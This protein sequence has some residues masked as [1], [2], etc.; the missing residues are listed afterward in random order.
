M[1]NNLLALCQKNQWQQC[2]PVA[3]ELLVQGSKQQG[4][5]ATMLG[6]IHCILGLSYHG[7]QKL[8]L[9]ILNFE[10]AFKY[11]AVQKDVGAQAFCLFYMGQIWH[12][13]GALQHLAKAL[14]CLDKALELVSK[15][16]VRLFASTSALT[17]VYFDKHGSK[18]EILYNQGLVYRSL[19]ALE[20]HSTTWLFQALECFRT[21][22][23]VYQG[24]SDY[25]G[26]AMALFGL[27]GATM[28]LPYPTDSDDFVQAV[29]Q[30]ISMYEVVLQMAA[31]LKDPQLQAQT[32][33]N[34]GVAHGKIGNVAKGLGM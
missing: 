12:D 32:I 17:S 6:D 8:D 31:I 34:L 16:N 11:Y 10:K 33:Q 18:A 15:L 22:Y 21:S 20:I 2:I 30:A 26:Q 24:A 25:P 19:Y 4:V 9:A 27:A 14:M 23:E 1:L 29:R 3:L 5:D 13:L 28:N 7:T